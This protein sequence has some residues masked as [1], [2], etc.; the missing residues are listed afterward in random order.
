MNDVGYGL[1]AS[2]CW[3][4]FVTV[5]SGPG[6]SASSF[7]A[8]FGCAALLVVPLVTVLRR[9]RT[10]FV[11]FR[12]AGAGAALACA[13]L[14][15]FGA[16]VFE[17]THH[18]ALGAVTFACVAFGVVGAAVLLARRVLATRRDWLRV[19]LIGVAALSVITTLG[20]VVGSGLH[21]AGPAR[22]LL[23]DSVVGGALVAACVVLPSM[24]PAPWTSLVALA[25]IIAALAGLAWFGTRPE[26]RRHLADSA[27]AATGMARL[28]LF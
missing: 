22:A 6:P 14:A 15:V 21:V 26:L 18:R 5:T 12:V 13:P 1:L 27:P 28:V 16:L 17:K 9:T 23:A 2:A 4:L 10:L 8:S 25:G 11:A 3:A 19:A 24:R 20:M 7:A